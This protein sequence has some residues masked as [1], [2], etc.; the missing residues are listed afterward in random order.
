MTKT[1]VN[2]LRILGTFAYLT[3]AACSGGKT[4]E[5]ASVKGERLPLTTVEVY[6]A[7]LT[8]EQAV[9]VKNLCELA[10]Y[11]HTEV[12][13]SAGEESHDSRKSGTALRYSAQEM[14][15]LMEVARESDSI[16][17]K[18]SVRQ[19]LVSAE[20]LRSVP[21]PNEGKIVFARKSKATTLAYVLTNEDGSPQLQTCHKESKTALEAS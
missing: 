13:F 8:L 9:A 14:N 6:G 21:V 16:W 4:E 18:K 12:K 5:K 19:G 10:F 17:L 7:D 20:L 1:C 3:L 2:G 15:A 11:I